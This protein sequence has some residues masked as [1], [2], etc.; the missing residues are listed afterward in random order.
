[1]CVPVSCAAIRFILGQI[2]ANILERVDFRVGFVRGNVLG[3]EVDQLAE[4]APYVH[5]EPWHC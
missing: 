2:F 3:F 4:G 1:M 5:T